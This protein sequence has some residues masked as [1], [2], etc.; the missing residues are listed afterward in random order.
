MAHSAAP[1]STSRPSDMPVNGSDPGVLAAG[2]ALG[3]LG[4]AGEMGE[5]AGV[6]VGAGPGRGVI[7][8]HASASNRSEPDVRTAALK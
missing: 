3:E 8:A 2:G 7:G 5:L 6:G 1:N 4:G